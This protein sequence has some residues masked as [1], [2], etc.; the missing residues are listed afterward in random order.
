M[1][2]LADII[3]ITPAFSGKQITHENAGTIMEY[4]R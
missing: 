2:R 3:S 1:S 4:N